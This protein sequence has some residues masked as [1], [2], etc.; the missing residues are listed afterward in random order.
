MSRGHLREPPAAWP[1]AAAGT[2]LREAAARVGAA[3]Q[4]LAG[5]S[6]ASDSAT[7][8]PLL[9]DAVEHRLDDRTDVDRRLA[10]ATGRR[11]VHALRTALV[12]GWTEGDLPTPAPA[13]TIAILRAL[14]D[15]YVDLEPDWTRDLGPLPGPGFELF[16]D[17]AHDLRSPLNS[18][19][20]LAETLQRGSSGAVTD[21]QRRQLGLIYSAALGLNNL[22]SDALELALDSDRLVDKEPAPFSVAEVIEAVRS[23]VHPVAEEKGLEM[24][25][26]PPVRDHRLGQPVALGRVL[27]N[28]T[29]NALKF[30]DDGYVEIAVAERDADHLEFSVRDTGPGVNPD[31][32]PSLFQ[33]FRRARARSGVFFS[34]TGLGLAISRKLVRAMGSELELETRPNWGTRFHFALTLPTVA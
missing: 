32:I 22:A 26:V 13:D 21:L 3:W 2:L 10:G 33:P 24:R 8:L 6:D 15:V 16:V 17:I 1:D 29:T 28:L 34:G 31:A 11:L 9:V 19:L 5:G 7:L 25:L 4:A 18:I 12:R 20:F 30:T 27:L 14:E 23:I